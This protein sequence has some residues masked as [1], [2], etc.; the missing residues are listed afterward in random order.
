MEIRLSDGDQ[1]DGNIFG[2]PVSPG[3]TPT[4]VALQ[5]AGARR[6]GASCSAGGYSSLITEIGRTQ[7]QHLQHFYTVEQQERHPVR[8]AR[9]HV[10]NLDP[11]NRPIMSFKQKSK[12]WSECQVVGWFKINRP[13]MTKVPSNP[14]YKFGGIQA[15]DPALLYVG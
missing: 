11:P 3:A 4:G 2:R 7:P 6:G 8:A 14:R 9:V 1:R 5:L 13:E 15:V 10:A 12:R